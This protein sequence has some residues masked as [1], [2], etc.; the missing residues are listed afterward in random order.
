MLNRIV[1]VTF[2]LFNQR[3]FAQKFLY[4]TEVGVN[5]SSR[6]YKDKRGNGTGKG[7]P[8]VSPLAGVSVT[9]NYWKRIALTAGARF[10]QSG[11]KYASHSTGVSQGVYYTHTQIEDFTFT[12]VALPVQLKCNFNVGKLKMNAFLGYTALNII[13]GRYYYKLETVFSRDVGRNFLHEK[14]FSPF[15]SDLETSARRTTSLASVGIGVKVSDRIGIQIGFSTALRQ[16]YFVEYPTPW[17]VP[18]LD[19]R[20]HFFNHNDLALSVKY[21]MNK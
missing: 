7:T 21:A 8:L 12:Q 14:S 9:T 1:I 18:D 17:I 4:E 6:P 2:I 16:I 3:A 15:S 20:R 11:K 10:Y 19:P 5:A 13:R